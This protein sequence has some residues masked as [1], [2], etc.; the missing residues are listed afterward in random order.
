MDA[1]GARIDATQ[2]VMRARGSHQ[3]ANGGL[4]TESVRGNADLAA[5]RYAMLVLEGL[6]IKYGS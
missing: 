1:A 5:Q 4:E 2:R 3:F 6:V